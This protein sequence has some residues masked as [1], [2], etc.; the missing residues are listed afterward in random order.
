MHGAPGWDE[1][2]PIGPFVC[3][4]VS[5]GRVG[6]QVRD[7][8]A[9][10]LARCT[11]AELRGGDPAGNAAR[12]RQALRGEDSKAHEDALIAGAALALEV[13]GRALSFA[14]GVELARK[15]LRDGAG[16]RFLE[17]LD[18]FAASE[19]SRAGKA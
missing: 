19:R 11:A 10:G 1:A 12:L 16:A 15:A 7:P 9:A 18:A 4:D 13:T 3:Y 17:R 5:D 6:R 2:T 14:A 8:E